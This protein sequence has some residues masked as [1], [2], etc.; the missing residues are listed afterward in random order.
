M[1]STHNELGISNASA[2]V[3]RS[4]VRVSAGEIRAKGS[5][6]IWASA[7]I[8]LALLALLALVIKSG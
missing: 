5:D 2:S 4:G 6:A 1:N 3:D 8:V 7:A